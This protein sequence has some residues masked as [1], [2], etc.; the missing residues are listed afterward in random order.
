MNDYT[1]GFKRGQSQ[2]YS[3]GSD[4]GITLFL[5]LAYSALAD[6]FKFDTDKLNRLR[7]RMDRYAMHIYDGLVK[8][9]DMKQCLLDQGIDLKAMGEIKEINGIN[10]IKAV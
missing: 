2:G 4:E 9:D 8:F 6:E 3:Q 10:N 1:R 7:K 5:V